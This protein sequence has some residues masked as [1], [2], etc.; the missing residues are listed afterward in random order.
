MVRF[1]RAYATM[2]GSGPMSEYLP[3]RGTHGGRDVW[4]APS[5]P[6]ADLMRDFGLARAPHR[7]FWDDHEDGLLIQD[8]WDR[9][10]QR[11]LDPDWRQGAH[12]LRYWLEHRTEDTGVQIICHS[13]GGQVAALGLGGL[14]RKGWAA[15]FPLGLLYVDTPLRDGLHDAYRAAA[16]LVMAS[17]APRPV[18]GLIV[19]M[20]SSAWNWRSWPRY[21]GA[22]KMWAGVIPGPRMPWS[23]GHLPGVQ[24]IVPVHGGH[25]DVLA[26]PHRHRAEWERAFSAA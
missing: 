1:S 25:S 15:P 21:L 24:R 20:R 11:E 13:H 3:I 7:D 8:G 14:F 6:F 16:D 2:S 22:R 10:R 26:Q 18:H 9:L 19:Q 5:S 4:A 17:P 12:H 23:P